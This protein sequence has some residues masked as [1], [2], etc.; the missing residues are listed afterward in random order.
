MI[1]AGEKDQWNPK[2]YKE[3]VTSHDNNKFMINL[4]V[5]QIKIMQVQ[6]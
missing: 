3:S 5:D 2:L 1:N 4:A 6:I